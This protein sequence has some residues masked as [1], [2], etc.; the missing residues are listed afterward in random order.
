MVVIFESLFQ[1]FSVTYDYAKYFSFNE[2]FL[3]HIFTIIYSLQMIIQYQTFSS[4]VIYGSHA[5]LSHESLMNYFLYFL[6]FLYLRLR[7]SDIFVVF[8][9]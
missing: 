9:R 3:Y 2:I 6:F 4:L 8:Y 5:Y 1:Y 7:Y